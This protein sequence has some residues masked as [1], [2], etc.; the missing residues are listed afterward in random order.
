MGGIRNFEQDLVRKN[1]INN[2]FENAKQAGG[3]I[4]DMHDEYTLMKSHNYKNTDDYY[5][6]KAN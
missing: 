1:L 3:A 2:A 6:C 4:R 5:H